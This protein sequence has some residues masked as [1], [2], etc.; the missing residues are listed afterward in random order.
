[1]VLCSDGGGGGADVAVKIIRRHDRKTGASLYRAAALNEI[2]VLRDLGGRHGTV[3]LL[4]DF[5]HARHVCMAF[6]VLGDSLHDALL[7]RGGRPMEPH[8]VRD[9]LHQV[10]ARRR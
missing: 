3:Q 4:H 6:E 9:V 10:R 8:A 1:M 5:E 2:R 7:A